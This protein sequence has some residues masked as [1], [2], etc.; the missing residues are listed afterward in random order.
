[1]AAVVEGSQHAEA[2]QSFLDYLS[3]DTARDLFIAA[4]F[5]MAE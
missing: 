2:A 1:P 5:E 4:G 3:S